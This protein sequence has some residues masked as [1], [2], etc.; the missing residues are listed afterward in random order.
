MTNE[1]IPQTAINRFVTGLILAF[2]A[3]PDRNSLE[4]DPLAMIIYGNDVASC[5][6][7]VL[8]K[9]RLELEPVKPDREQ[10]LKRLDETLER[11]GKTSPFHRW[12]REEWNESFPHAQDNPFT[13]LNWAFFAWTHLCKEPSSMPAPEFEAVGWQIHMSCPEDETVDTGWVNCKDQTA[14]FYRGKPGVKL[15]RIYVEKTK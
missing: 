9:E 12:F 4:D 7:N 13:A 5:V 3:I 2:S 8:E 11:L 14:E 10:T 1:S 6:V 15:R